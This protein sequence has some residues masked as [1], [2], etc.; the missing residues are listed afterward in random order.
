MKDND[1]NIETNR[2]HTYKKSK[3][4]IESFV[5][6]PDQKFGVFIYNIEEWRMGTY[7]GQLAIYLDKKSDVP[8]IAPE[9]IEVWYTE[10]GFFDYAPLSACLIFKMLAFRESENTRELPLLLIKP[11]EGVFAFIDWGASSIQCHVVEEEKNVVV[12]KKSSGKFRIKESAKFRPNEKINLEDLQWTDLS[13]IE[14]AYNLYHGIKQ[15]SQRSVR[16]GGILFRWWRWI[17]GG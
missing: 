10:K 12:V 4:S 7:A 17:V 14:D 5:D 13:R 2:L 11:I 6:T 3:W 8:I 16:T 15:N 1:W 9:R